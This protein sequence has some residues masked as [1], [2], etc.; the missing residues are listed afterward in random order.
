MTRKVLITSALLY[1]NGSLHFGHVAGAYLTADIYARF[2]RLQGSE[3]LFLSGSDEFGVAVT[4]SAELAGRT[5]Q[6]QVDHFHA[7]NKHLFDRL[8]ISFDHFARTTWKDHHLCVD[9]YFNDLLQGGYI[10][11]RDTE[12]LYSEE[13]KRFFADRYVTGTCPRCGFTSARGDE[14]QQCG[15]SY[16]ATDLHDPRSKLSGSPLTRKTTRHW[17]LLLDRLQS[18]LESFLSQKKWKPNVLNFAK[19]YLENLHPRAITRDGNWGIPVPLLEG[20]DKV[21]YVWF[22]A[23]IGYLSATREWNEKRWKE[24]WCD[25]QTHLVQFVGKDNIFFH[26][27]FFPAMTMGQN[28]PYKLVDDLPASE[29]LLLEGRQFSKS[30]GWHIDLEEFLNTYSADQLRYTLAA[31]APETSDSEFTWRDFQNRCNSDLVGKYGNLANRTFVFLQ[32]YLAGR[33]PSCDPDPA[34]IEQIKRIVE[35]AK[36][37]YAS[38]SSRR[39]CALIMELASLGNVYF[40]HKQPWKLAKDASQGEALDQVI[41]SCLECLGALA[42]ISFP[43]IPATATKLWQM[44]GQEGEPKVWSQS[45]VPHALPSPELLFHKVEDEQIE[46]ELAKLKK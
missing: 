13:E 44:L 26:A 18:Q 6:E 21:F 23:C 39:A 5:P 22:E 43:I 17:F 42:F 41:R 15:A 2:E 33:F 11:A 36:E 37:A 14:C 25:P 30:D 3:V 40:D 1:A 38:Y 12:Q 7:I 34:F 4:L 45:L 29:F 35:E 32:R 19:H 10:E 27:L 16:E 20:K 28:E 46:A 24:F 9:Q 31:N 8:N